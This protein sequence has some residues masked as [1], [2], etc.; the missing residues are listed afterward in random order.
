MNPMSLELK[1]EFKDLSD[2]ELI[3]AA[4]KHLDKNIEEMQGISYLCVFG[5]IYDM[6][7][8]EIPKEAVKILTGFSGGF[9]LSGRYVCGALS[10]GMAA[11]GLV[12]GSP[13]P[14]EGSLKEILE[15]DSLEEKQKQLRSLLWKNA[16]YNQL[17]NRFKKKFGSCTCDKLIEQWNE[18][19]FDL[20]RTKKCLRIMKGTV[21]MV[22]E[23][24]LEAEEKGI[25][26][27][28]FGDMT[29]G[30]EE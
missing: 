30:H 8:T 29:W 12:Y 2:R 27:F 18:D 1:E 9:G 24:I 21:E 14:L 6:I 28:D 19:P 16:I 10:G 13:N 20:E 4:K 5:S 26:S 17:V 25:D 23:L 3:S 7:E 11:L 15:R 22:M